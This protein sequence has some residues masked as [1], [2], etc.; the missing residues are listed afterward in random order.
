MNLLK[1]S[2]WRQQELFAGN[3][4]E[5]NGRWLCLKTIKKILIGGN[6]DL[7]FEIL[8][9]AQR[10]TKKETSVWKFQEK[11]SSYLM[12]VF[13]WKKN[14]QSSSTCFCLRRTSWFM[15]YCTV[16]VWPVR[17]VRY[18]YRAMMNLSPIKEKCARL[19]VPL[20]PPST[21]ET[22]RINF[23]LFLFRLST[24]PSIENGFASNDCCDDGDCGN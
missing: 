20:L 11:R 7:L 23:E 24:S 1:I 2:G 14:I 15:F 3:V 8:T 17:C 5:H 21:I 19:T 12:V 6:W 16:W 22:T 10:T 13:R 4:M 18:S 9:S